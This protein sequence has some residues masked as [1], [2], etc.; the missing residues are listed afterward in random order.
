M[1]VGSILLAAPVAA[2]TLGAL[3]AASPPPA[4]GTIK[5]PTLSVSAWGDNSA[6]DLGDGS[7]AA[8]LVPGGVGSLTGVRSISAGGRHGL[9]L[10]ANGT[11]MAWGDNA[12]G[13]DG[14]G[15]TS[16]DAL[17]PV[18]VKGLS[19]VVQVSAG[20]EHSL[21]LLANGTVM[22]WGDNF[23]G[24]LGD[25]GTKSSAVPV[26][27]KGLTHV[28][29]ISAGDTFSL[30][31]LANGTVMAW[32]NNANGQLGNGT[33][34]NQSD[35]PEPVTGL[36][37]VTAVAAGGQ[38]SLALQSDGQ[39][40]AWG[41]DTDGQLGTGDSSGATSLPGRVVDLTHAVAIAAGSDFSLALTADG[42]V[43][44]WGDNGFF[45][46]A[47][48]QGFPGGIQSSDVPV[49]IPGTGK[50]TAI[51]AG[52]LF[53]LALRE[54]GTVMGW[55]DDA[56]G[57]LG[58]D[59]TNTQQAATAVQGLTGVHA[60]AAGGPF[61]A[62]L[63][64]APAGKSPALSPSPWSVSP[65]PGFA[66][67]DINNFSLA[68]VSAHGPDSAWAVGASSNSN[69]PLAEQWT[70]KA[71]TATPVT[72]PAGAGS[73]TLSG[74]ADLG[75][76]DAW[77]VG[78]SATEFG[79]SQRTLIE[80]WNGTSWS[81][82]PSPDP[83]TGAGAFDVLTSISATGPDDVWA[84]GWFSPGE[85]FIALLL[86][87]WNGTSWSL[88][89]P[90]TEL[91]TQLGDGVVAIS[92]HDVWIVGD[93]GGQQTVTAHWNGSTWT[94]PPTPFL[95]QGHSVNHLTGVTAT[96]P[97]NI[98]ASGYASNSPGAQENVPYL[99]HWTGK[100]WTLVKVPD[101]GTEGSLL[102]ATT[103]LSASSVWSVGITDQTDGALL[104]LAEH[105]NGKTW[106]VS[107]SSDPGLNS[108]LPDD[109]L[110]GIASAPGGPVWAVGAQEVTGQCC[111]RTLA[112]RSAS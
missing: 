96:G 60:I 53:G 94:Q 14:N 82:V 23:D 102:T 1:R 99:L 68:A 93:T 100:A 39:V 112:L 61:A 92:A 36:T 2:I 81:I 46:L 41:E 50:A 9:A 57:Q 40:M 76:Q 10:L 67:R 62:A 75:P 71:W 34:D 29:A 7:L 64:T 42:V 51:A 105:F 87:H 30:A 69:A 72:G 80:H 44:G 91:A 83:E 107:P 109:S 56:F 45:E 97:D 18:P 28:T 103:A 21:A 25:G 12:F 17:L 31:A 20:S 49:T 59:T 79:T 38:H 27:V 86:E 66:P 74:V 11:V 32:G 89:P 110:A 101:P 47:Q 16:D 33:D 65:T 84:A 48:P 6:G 98:W 54:N 78:D 95:Q 13:A 22:A 106:T 108:A 111:L 90:P 24:Q 43:K 85:N 35:V 15:R 37:G 4:Q 58:N 5:T 104:S 88:I 55:G 73:A 19:S 77:A 52:A 70:G 26:R 3:L 63:T 8:R